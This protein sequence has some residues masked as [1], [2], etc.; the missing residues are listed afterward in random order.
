MGWTEYQAEK[1]YD[2]GKINRKAECDSYFL[3]GLN[4]GW[5]D[6]VRSTMKGSVYYAAVTK[7]KRYGLDADGHIAKDTN[8][9]DI[10]EDIPKSAQETVGV[11]ILTSVRGSWFAYKDISETMGPCY[12]DCPNAILDLLS[13]T[14]NSCAIDWREKCRNNN[15]KQS[16]SKLPI[17]T[18]IEFEHCGKTITLRK[19]APC[20]QF[21]TTF[22]INDANCTYYSKK[23]I[24]RDF[25]VVKTP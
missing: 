3:E 18:E 1:F 13:P 25:K 10:V 19:S 7:I 2:N 12:Y 9:D 20:Y 15:S 24:P 21:K 11:V 6:V 17:G 22:W 14:T 23:R 8:E 16:I 5:Y 4:R